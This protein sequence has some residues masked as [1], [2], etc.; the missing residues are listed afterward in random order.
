MKHIFIVNPV[1]GKGKYQL[2][3]IKNIE[4]Q[5]YGKTDFEIYITKSKEDVKRYV[6]SKC[7]ENVSMVLYAC[8]GD[9]TLHDVINSAQDYEQ[10]NIGIIPCGTGNDY[11]KNF[12]NYY[13]FND[14]IAQ[15]EGSKVELDLI[16]VNDEYAA[17]VCNIGFDADAAFNM[18]KFKSIPFI[19]GTGCY[20]LSV[21]YSLTKKLG[22]NLEVEVDD[23]IKFNGKFLLGVI[24]NGNSYGGGYKCA[25]KAIINDGIIDICFIDKISRFK[26]LGLI[27]EY[28]IGKHLENENIKK[29]VTY[30]KCKTV[31]MKCDNPI[32]LCIDG[33]SSIHNELFFE[34][35]HKSLR[36]W[37]PKGTKPIYV[38]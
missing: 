23:K 19:T 2:E 4:N 31:R 20:I 25:P 22:K 24:A 13:N 38:V 11:V 26:I 17:S 14:V 8:G 34:I 6:I 7:K 35:S 21:L 10:V 27:N 37:I 33:E 16:K 3:I 12:E 18:H 29:Y 15:I 36:F 5:L 28:K 9:G 1:A 32:N 30:K